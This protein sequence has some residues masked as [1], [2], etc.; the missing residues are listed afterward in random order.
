[1]NGLGALERT[2]MERLWAVDGPL[3]VREVHQALAVDR[4]LAY[5]TVMTVLDRLAKK[6]LVQRDRDGRAYLYRPAR[7]REQLVAEAMETALGEGGGSAPADR[8]AALVEFVGRV[9]PEEADAMR[10]ALARLEAGR[11]TG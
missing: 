3:S 1:M 4:D 2:V 7:T 6:Q 5:T 9:S 8:N 10:A 11:T